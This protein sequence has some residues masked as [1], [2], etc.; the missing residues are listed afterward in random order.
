MRN[1]SPESVASNDAGQDRKGSEIRT[2]LGESWELVL[3]TAA[4]LDGDTAAA[5]DTSSQLRWRDMSTTSPGA[6]VDALGKMNQMLGIPGRCCGSGSP[7]G[8]IRTRPARGVGPSGDS[9]DKLM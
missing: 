3:R 2:S 7:A 6:I 8:R 9:L 4:A 1:V 5:A